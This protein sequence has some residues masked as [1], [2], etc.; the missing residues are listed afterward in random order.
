MKFFFPEFH[1]ELGKTGG[2]SGSIAIVSDIARSFKKREGACEIWFGFADSGARRT[3]RHYGFF[4][5]LE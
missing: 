5:G 2:R 3:N 1:L 4:S